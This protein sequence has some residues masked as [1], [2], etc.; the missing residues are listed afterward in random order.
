MRVLEVVA[1]ESSSNVF[2]AETSTTDGVVIAEDT[3]DGVPTTYGTGS[4]KLDP[5]TC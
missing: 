4:G 3:T 1:R 2:E 5:S